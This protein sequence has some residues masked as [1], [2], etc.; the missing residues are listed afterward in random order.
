MTPDADWKTLDGSPR[1]ISKLRSRVIVTVIATVMGL[2]VVEGYLRL[3]D[4]QPGV[5]ALFLPPAGSARSYRLK[6]NL[7]LAVPVE[8]TTI[9]IKTNSHGMRWREVDL[10]KPA[11]M[12]RVAFVGDSFAFGQWSDSAEHSLVGTFD[13][14]M[15]TRG[16]DVLN[17]G[18]PGYGFLEVEEQLET[19]V[20]AFQPDYI[21]LLS[22]NG[23]DFADTY[24]GFDRY[25]V[26]SSGLLRS[27]ADHRARTIPAEFMPKQSSHPGPLESIYLY[28]VLQRARRNMFSPPPPPD[29]GFPPRRPAF[30]TD[31]TI[32]A[33]FWS[34]KAY[35]P[36]AEQARKVS[37]EALERI[38]KLCE[39]NGA[40][41]III[42]IPTLQQIYFA[43]AFPESHDVCRPQK[44]VE[45]F[46]STRQIPYLDLL[47]PLA[48]H[49]RRTG[50]NLHFQHE[51]H[52]N[53]EGHRVTG[54]LI[55]DSFK[56]LISGRL[57]GVPGA[58]ESCLATSV[59]R[60]L[61]RTRTV[62]N[63]HG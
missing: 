54:E 58:D 36:F 46:A 48:E 9:S 44:Y 55:A 60:P 45:E 26:G 22:F 62:A 39:I 11:G 14:R 41:L 32:S 13:S 42:T 2:G 12:T 40:R 7:N 15:R 29:S 37:I 57:S 33:F 20:K 6:P 19:D 34:R 52:F 43:D 38:A 27:N 49:Y 30:E 61:S 10:L 50:A 4:V 23:N 59:L 63:A 3:A 51:G 17:F 24:M 5:L 53:N 35:P 1:V 8:T 28:N 16:F 21:V 31:N 47:P 25:E 56:E 18:V